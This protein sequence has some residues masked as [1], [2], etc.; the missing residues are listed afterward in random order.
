MAEVTLHDFAHSFGTNPDTFSEHCRKIVYEKNFEYVIQEGEQRDDVILDVLKKI[1]T[2]VQVIGTPERR[3]VWLRGWSENL[4]RY[5]DTGGGMDALIPK[6]IRGNQCARYEGNYIQPSSPTFELD[7]LTVFRTWLFENYFQAFDSIYEFGSGTGFNLVLLSQLFPK[8]ELHGLDFVE[9]SV[10]LINTVAARTKVNIKGTLFDMEAPPAN[11]RL[12]RN[13]A[14]F[15]IGA[16]EQLAGRFEN[17]LQFILRE[18]P[19]L[20]V[21]VEPTAELYDQNSLFDYLALKFHRKRGYTEG[22]LPRLQQ[23]ESQHEIKIHKIKRLHFGNLMMEG[24]TC[25]VWEP[26]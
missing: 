14:I 9:S 11:F 3:D 1:D 5:V 16:M 23:L 17:F 25:M 6:F 19:R 4:E 15:T 18:R 22:F 7:F 24:Y 10:D 12:A 21:H 13:N 8:K 20:C 2:D 26:A